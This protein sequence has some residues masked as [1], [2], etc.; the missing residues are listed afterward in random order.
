MFVFPPQKKKNRSRLGNRSRGSHSLRKFGFLMG[1]IVVMT[2]VSYRSE[3]ILL[4]SR[5]RTLSQVEETVEFTRKT[6]E[7]HGKKSN[8][9][10]VRPH[11]KRTVY[12]S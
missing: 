1:C 6:L 3:R 4:T 2:L 10:R 5:Q 12:V 8:T 11:N 7:P 9:V